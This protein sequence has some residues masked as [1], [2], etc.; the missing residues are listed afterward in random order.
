[1][2]V[3]FVNPM[4]PLPYPDPLPWVGWG[5]TYFTKFF[6]GI[7]GRGNN[8]KAK[9]ITRVLKHNGT[10][11]CLFGKWGFEWLSMGGGGGGDVQIFHCFIIAF[12]ILVQSIIFTYF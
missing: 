3:S 9:I 11:A 7:V 1:M 10:Y 6:W 2:P 8:K 4:Y 5:V 12:G